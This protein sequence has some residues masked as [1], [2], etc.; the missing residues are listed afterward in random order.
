MLHLLRL[1]HN[2]FEAGF[3]P[4]SPPWWGYTFLFQVQT[5]ALFFYGQPDNTGQLYVKISN[6]EPAYPG[7]A[8]DITLEQ[9]QRWDIDLSA[10]NGLQSVTELATGVDGADAAGMLYIDGIRLYP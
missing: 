9:W 6:T 10:V 5:R 1:T 3:F 8:T 2:R 4:A 7:D